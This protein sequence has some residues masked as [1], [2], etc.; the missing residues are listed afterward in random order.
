MYA[1]MKPSSMAWERRRFFLT[2]HARRFAVQF[3]ERVSDRPLF[4]F[5]GTCVMDVCIDEAIKHGMG[6]TPVFPDPPRPPLRRSISRAR[7]RPPIV[8]LQRDLRDGCMH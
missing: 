3:L 1:L 5:N 7:L 2:R 4:C 8:L 6:T